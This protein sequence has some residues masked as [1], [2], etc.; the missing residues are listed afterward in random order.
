MTDRETR[1][2]DGGAPRRPTAGVVARAG[3]TGGQAMASL[4][5]MFRE[6]GNVR[7]LTTI[8]SS[9]PRRRIL[10][11]NHVRPAPPRGLPGTSLGLNGFRAWLAGPSDRYERCPCS[12]AP[13]L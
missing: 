5:Q 9:V 11:H 13:H 7:Y 4:N 1:D 3:R 12:W 8:P 2:S 6:I 10:V